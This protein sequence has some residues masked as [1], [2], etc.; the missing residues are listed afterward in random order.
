MKTKLIPLLLI[1]ISLFSFGQKQGNIWYFGDHAGLNFNSGSPIAITNG[2]NALIGCPNSCHSE[3]TSVVCDS[4]G[5]LLF[6]SN[7]QQ[8]WNRNHQL[9]VN[10]DSLLGNCSSSQ[11]TLIVPQPGSS[12]YFYIFTTDAFYL[13]YLQYGFRYSIVDICG[14]NGFGDIIPNQKNIKLLD[15]VGEKLTA[16]RHSNGVDYW[17]LTHKFYSNAFYAYLLTSAGIVDTV[18]THIGSI[19]KEYCS[20]STYPTRSALGWL[21][22]SPNGNKITCVN[23]QTCYNIS[24]LFDFNNTTGQLSNAIKLNTDSIAGG[25]YGVSFSPDNSKL[26]IS[27]WL[28]HD[29][30][31]QFDLTAGSGDSISINNSKAVI[32]DSYFGGNLVALQ[33]G[34]NGKIYVSRRNQT[35]IGAINN[36]N[37]AGTNCNYIDTAVSLNGKICSFGLPNFIDFS[38]YSNTTFNCETGINV[39]NNNSVSLTIYPNP[40]FDN[41]T[42]MLPRSISKTEIKIFNMLGE[43]EYSSTITMQKIDIDVSSLTSGLHLIQI[44]T[45][46]KISRQKFIRK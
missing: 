2:A 15:T 21:K 8:I 3:G 25:Y 43:L 7:G 31:Y 33:L 23:G 12:R 37:I 34:P 22:A 40:A 45:G 1:S 46:D 26:Y 16:I 13:D 30:I 38:Q 17:V 5:D 28:N 44:A 20:G 18:I 41:L 4:S 42:V 39:P 14:D 29:R 6:Y 9:M 36:P 32:A 19:H 11:A 24:E 10:G 35:F 27:C